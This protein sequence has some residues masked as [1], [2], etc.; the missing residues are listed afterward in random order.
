M[1]DAVAAAPAKAKKAS[2]PK[3]PSTHPKYSEM[4]SAALGA[5]KERS[6]SSRHLRRIIK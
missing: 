4:I 6:G 1:T 2:K 3:K 5:L